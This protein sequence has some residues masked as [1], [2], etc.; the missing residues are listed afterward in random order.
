M[1][2]T[3]KLPYCWVEGDQLPNMVCTFLDQDLSA[4][5]VTFHMRRNDGSVLIKSATA[6]DLSQGKFRIEWDSSDL[7]AGFNQESE[8]QF[9]NGSSKPLTSPKFLIDV[10]AAIS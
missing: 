10:R 2:T 1:A 9:V 4:F 5:T 3:P 6:I 7:V 8:F